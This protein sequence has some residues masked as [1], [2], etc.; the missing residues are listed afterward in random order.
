MDGNGTLLCLRFTEVLRS[1]DAARD[2][3]RSRH[4]NTW[5]KG[6]S[7]LFP[8]E[9]LDPPRSGGKSDARRSLLS[10]ELNGVS[11]ARIEPT[12]CIR[13][14]IARCDRPLQRSL[15]LRWFGEPDDTD[16]GGGRGDRPRVHDV[17]SQTL[18][19]SEWGRIQSPLSRGISGEN[20]KRAPAQATGHY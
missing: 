10:A 3:D 8:Q 15:R 20:F 12:N 1:I 16:S 17:L 18:D 13:E 14:S 5:S 9:N 6:S 19:A 4:P 2:L 7:A 11:D